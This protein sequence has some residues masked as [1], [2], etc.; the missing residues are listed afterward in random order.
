MGV[1]PTEV[2]FIFLRR[3]A[4]LCR[5]RLLFQ[6]NNPPRGRSPFRN[7]RLFRRRL[8]NKGCINKKYTGY[9]RQKTLICQLKEFSI[10]KSIDK[11]M[12]LPV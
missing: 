1:L 2:G 7:F 6:K 12:F 3:A 8:P 10:H 9:Y 5:I 4:A 11:S